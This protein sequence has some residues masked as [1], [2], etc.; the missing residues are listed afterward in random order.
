[1]GKARVAY[2]STFADRSD[3]HE[4]ASKEGSMGL[5]CS[6]SYVE[7]DRQ[8]LLDAGLDYPY[9]PKLYIQ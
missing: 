4:V 5:T 1:M 2:F 3:N 9:Q 7:K 6:F 8:P